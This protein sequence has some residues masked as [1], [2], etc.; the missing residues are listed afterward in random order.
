MVVIVDWMDS[1][2]VGR[3]AWTS[4]SGQLPP[5]SWSRCEYQEQCE[6]TATS[7]LAVMVEMVGC[8]GEVWDC[9]GVSDVSLY[10]ANM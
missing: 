4:R 9:G 2:S 3:S 6:Y 8:G 5:A 10:N 1:S 7:W